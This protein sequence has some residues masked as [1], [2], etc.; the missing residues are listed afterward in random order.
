M[1]RKTVMGGNVFAVERLI[2][3]LTKGISLIGSHVIMRD[4]LMQ[5]FTDY[6]KAE[7]LSVTTGITGA[8]RCSPHNEATFENGC[9]QAI[10]LW[11]R[12]AFGVWA[13]SAGCP[14]MMMRIIY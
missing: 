12:D 11:V 5:H 2:F 8:W 3:I 13:D 14:I 1:L 7:L 4:G 9:R 10:D 6:E